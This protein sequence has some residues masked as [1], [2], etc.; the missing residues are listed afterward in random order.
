[1]PPLRDRTQ[2]PISTFN[3]EPGSLLAGKY[4]IVE[5]LGRG[6]EGE[7]YLG[8][9]RSTRIERS[10]KL[11]FPQRNPGNRT[12][13]QFARKLHKLRN[14]PILVQYR[15][16]EQMDFEGRAVT[17]L[18][19]DYVEGEPLNEFIKRQPGRRLSF[20]QSLHM[21]HDLAAGMEPIHAMREYHGDIHEENIIIRRSGLSFDIRLLDMYNLGRPSSAMIQRD[22]HDMIRVF[23]NAMGGQRH[24]AN[25]APEIKQI[26]CGLKKTLIDR[27]YRNAGQLRRYLEGMAWHTR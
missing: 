11:F 7:V 12:V 26:C 20:F 9:E 23:Y 5:C 4:T 27:Q 8:R 22:V 25:H 2:R 14:C 3:L 19:S 10:L 17:L 13:R 1:M 6:Y 16:Q 24:Y 15:H 18:V 21:L